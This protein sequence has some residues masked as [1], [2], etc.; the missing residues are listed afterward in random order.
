[1]ARREADFR[2]SAE[3]S[4]SLDELLAVLGAEG[5]DARSRDDI[6]ACALSAS[7]GWQEAVKRLGGAFAEEAARLRERKGE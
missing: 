2:S 4:L 6:I 3:A 7:D 1:M 5:K